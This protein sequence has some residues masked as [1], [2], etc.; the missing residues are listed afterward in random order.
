VIGRDTRPRTGLCGVLVSRFDDEYGKALIRE[1]R[2]DRISL[3]FASG[4]ARRVG[5]PVSGYV[6]RISGPGLDARG[7]GCGAG[8]SL[9]RRS[10]DERDRELYENG[11]PRLHF[12]TAI[13]ISTR[14]N[15]LGSRHSVTDENIISAAR[16]WAVPQ[17]CSDTVGRRH[18]ELID[19]R[20]SPTRP[21]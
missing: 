7:L 18:S 19:N 16:L 21:N 13:R 20:A 2:H 6:E 3:A 11:H 5:R 9:D 10:G 1:P 8:D 15:Y 14:R 17:T 12:L 4:R